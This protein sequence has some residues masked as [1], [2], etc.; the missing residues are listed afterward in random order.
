[1]AAAGKARLGP[2]CLGALSVFVGRRRGKQDG[3]ET[4][5]DIRTH[6]AA[7]QLHVQSGGDAAEIVYDKVSLLVPGE[8]F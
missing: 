3:R 5:H 7:H 1:M 2:T 4:R 6:N 8:V